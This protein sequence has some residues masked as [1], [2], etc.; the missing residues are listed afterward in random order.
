MREQKG[1]VRPDMIHLLL[2]TRKGIDRNDETN[3]IDTGFATAQ[4][5]STS[6]GNLQRFF[7]FYIVQV[8]FYIIDVKYEH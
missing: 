7:L 8:T 4:E 5:S 1:I 6:Q 3:D 2:E